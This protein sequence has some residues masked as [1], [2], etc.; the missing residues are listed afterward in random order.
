M[1]FVAYFKNFTEDRF[2]IQVSGSF[3][4]VGL[5]QGLIQSLKI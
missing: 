3:I 5:I 1:Y 2:S 4:I